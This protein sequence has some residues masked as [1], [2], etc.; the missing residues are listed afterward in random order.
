[1]RI[2]LTRTDKIALLQAIEKGELDTLKVPSLFQCLEGGNAFLELMKALPDED[3][4]L[5]P[6]SDSRTAGEVRPSMLSEI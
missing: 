2:I 1:M 4:P 5:P 6:K 3:T